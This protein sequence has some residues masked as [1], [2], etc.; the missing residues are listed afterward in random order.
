MVRDHKAAGSSPATPTMRSVFVGFE[1][2]IKDTPFFYAQTR[3]TYFDG[4]DEKSG[5]AVFRYEKTV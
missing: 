1:Y 5:I 3:V 4:K 2:P